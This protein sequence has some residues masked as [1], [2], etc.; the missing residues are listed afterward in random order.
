M[1][2]YLLTI[3][4]QFLNI[5]T[6]SEA[7]R[8]QYILQPFLGFFSHIISQVQNFLSEMFLL[9]NENIHK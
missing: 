2:V 7:H 4:I 1:S 3:F 9:M 6:K 8:K 5:A